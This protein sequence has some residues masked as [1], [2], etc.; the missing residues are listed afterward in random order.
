MK[1]DHS[2]YMDLAIRLSLK[3]KGKTLPNPMV[4][5]VVVKNGRIIARGYHKKAGLPHAEIIALDEAGQAAK[6][7]ILYVTLEPCAMCAGA[8]V[9]ARINRLVF[10]ANDPKSGAVGSLMN[11]ASD[12]RFNH[13]VEIKSGILVEEC[14]TLLK[15][16]F[17]SRRKK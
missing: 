9:L 11:L 4:G 15:E 6:G 8:M 7:A 3:A 17:A 16:F 14:A 13:Q 12:E 10:G 2:Y 1:K 5:A